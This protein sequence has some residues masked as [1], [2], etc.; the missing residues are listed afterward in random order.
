MYIGITKQE[1]KK[2]RVYCVETNTVYDSVQEF[3]RKLNLY[4]TNIKKVCK[5]KHIIMIQ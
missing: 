1:P 3:A 5:G 4:A 2:R